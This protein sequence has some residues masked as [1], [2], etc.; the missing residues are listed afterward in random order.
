MTFME[1]NPFRDENFLG[2]PGNQ[3]FPAIY[4]IFHIFFFFSENDPPI[5]LTM[6]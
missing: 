3:G 5:H 2:I 1:T 6:Q 4:G